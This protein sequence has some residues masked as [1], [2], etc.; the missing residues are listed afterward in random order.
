MSTISH[1]YIY[2]TVCHVKLLK[3][4]MMYVFI[5]FLSRQMAPHVSNK[6]AIIAGCYISPD[7]TFEVLAFLA[8]FVEETDVGKL[9][10]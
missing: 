1:T 2:L 10:A 3:D 5:Y 7:I 4:E 9:T 8:S 6:S